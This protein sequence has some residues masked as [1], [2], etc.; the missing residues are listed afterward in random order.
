MKSASPGRRGILGPGLWLSLFLLLPCL[1]LAKPAFIIEEVKIRAVGEELVVDARF[2]PGLTPV[3]LEALDNG[4]PLIFEAHIQ[5][6]AANAWIWDSSLVDRRLRYE[7]RYQPLAERYQVGSLPAG[8]AGHNYVTRDAALAALGDL[9]DIPLLSRSELLAGQDYQVDLKV[10]LDIEE[11][12]L[13]LRPT[14]YL[15]PSWKLSS[16]WTSWPLRP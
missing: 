1:V 16:G 4:V 7:I 15:L 3:A 9:H 8:A 14:A 11:L 10:S 6:R 2:S 13:P 5:V 12:P